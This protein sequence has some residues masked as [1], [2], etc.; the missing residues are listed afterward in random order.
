MVNK[1]LLNNLYNDLDDDVKLT[2]EKSVEK[3][4]ETKRSNKKVV[5]VTGSGPNLHEGVTTLIAELIKKGIIDGVTTSSAVVA[6]EMGG[7]LDKVKRVDGR[8]LGFSEDIL[9][10]GNVFEVT[11]LENNLLAELKNE[12]I[13]DEKLIENTLKLDGDIIIKA[14]GNMAYPMGLR[15]ENLAKEILFIAKSKS[16]SFEEIAGAGADVNT[17]LGA[18]K[19]KGI[20]CLVTVPQ[21]IGGGMVGVAIGDSISIMERTSRIAEMLSSADV[22][23]ESAVALTQEIHDGP[24]ETYTGHGIW[25]DW[26]GYPTYSLKEKTLIRIDL[27]SNLK[28]AHDFENKSN[29]VQ[30]AI[31]KGMPK[32]KLMSIPFRMEMSGFAR[33]ENSIPIIGDIGVIWPIMANMISE[34]LNIELDFM[35]YP[36]QTEEGKKMREWIVE[37]IKPITKSELFS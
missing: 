22:I 5:V 4:V 11:I 33:L 28:K 14:A 26:E 13:I 17:M 37:N 6:H 18:A 19:R 29:T 20:P 34:Q 3:I 35:S 16:I 31:D 24:F 7:V 21:L 36:Q 30:E 1:E 2:I 8:K 12:M 25:S 15:T 27:D 23:I 32:T 10:R 9:P